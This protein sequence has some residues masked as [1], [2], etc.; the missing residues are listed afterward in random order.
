MI[1]FC[2]Q[3]TCLVD[4]GKTMDVVCLDINK[5]FDTISHGVFLEKV[6]A[7]G[8]EGCTLCWVKKLTRWPG[9]ETGGEWD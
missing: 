9:L 3:V 5:A 8:L 2:N 1:S 4:E 7:H 6:V